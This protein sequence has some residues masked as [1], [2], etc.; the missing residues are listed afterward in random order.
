MQPDARQPVDDPH[1]IRAPSPGHHFRLDEPPPQE[2]S[3]ESVHGLGVVGAEDPAEVV[4]E[5]EVVGGGGGGTGAGGGLVHRADDV[6]TAAAKYI[7][8]FIYINPFPDELLNLLG[9]VPEH[10]L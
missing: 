10:A 6:Q 7:L 3:K 5:L 9:I 8:N 4:V 1:K 2:A